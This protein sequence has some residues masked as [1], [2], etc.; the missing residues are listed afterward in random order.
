MANWKKWGR[1]ILWFGL[2]GAG[3]FIFLNLDVA[4]RKRELYFLFGLSLVLFISGWVGIF[5]SSKIGR[6]LD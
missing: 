4:N 5:M 2:I 1:I 3:V 6:A